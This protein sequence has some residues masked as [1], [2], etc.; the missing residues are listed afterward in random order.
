VIEE[1]IQ[2]V[3]K[4]KEMETIKTVFEKIALNSNKYEFALLDDI[5]STSEKLKKM[6]ESSLEIAVDGASK[7]AT[8]TSKSSKALNDQIF[9]L[10]KE[11]QEFDKKVK[12]L[13][14]NI[15][16]V[17]NFKKFEKEL[18]IAEARSKRIDKIVQD[19]KNIY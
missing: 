14:I 15:N 16:D 7:L 4:F 17:P 18:Q 6:W 1:H 19:L 5:K 11:I 10:K 2:Q 13:G 8:K 3:N 9:E 12:D